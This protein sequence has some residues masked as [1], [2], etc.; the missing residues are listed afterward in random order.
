MRTLAALALALAVTGCETFQP[1]TCDRDPESNPEV[2]F[3]GGESA[4]GVYESAPWDGELLNFPGGMRYEIVHDL[5]REPTWVELYLS[6]DRYGT[7]DGGKVA[8]AAGN[9]AVVVGADRSS[10]HV[11]NDTCVAYWVRVV[12]GTGPRP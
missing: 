10:I 7:T 12:A 3:T 4:N 9:Q 2:T 6:F 5:G 8:Q 1:I 11:V